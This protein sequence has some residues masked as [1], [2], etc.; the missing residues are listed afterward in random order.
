MQALKVVMSK[1]YIMP[2]KNIHQWLNVYVIK[3]QVKKNTK[4]KSETNINS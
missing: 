1:E 4:E 3:S 2:W